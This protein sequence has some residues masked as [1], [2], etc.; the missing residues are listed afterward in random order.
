MI[1]S[2]G[3]FTPA[4]ASILYALFAKTI[5]LSFVT[6]F[7]TFLG[8]VLSR[9]S[10]MKTSRG[11]TIAEMTMRQWVIQPAFMITHWEH[12]QHASLTI[13]GAISLVAALIAMLYTTASDAIVS[14]HLKYGNWEG[15]LMKGIVNASYANPIYVGESCQTPISFKVDSFSPQTCTDIQHAGQCRFIC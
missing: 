12:I 6:V 9:R 2:G 7:V 10:I 5:E 14:P 15:K 1:H 4:T 13:V 8:Q 3:S 11:V